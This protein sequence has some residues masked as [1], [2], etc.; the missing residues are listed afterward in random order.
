MEY[1]VAAT[2]HRSTRRRCRPDGLLSTPGTRTGTEVRS[3]SCSRGWGLITR[4]E[5]GASRAR[6][7]PMNALSRSMT[8]R[9]FWLNSTTTSRGASPGI[10]P[11]PET[12]RG[13]P[14]LERLRRTGISRSSSYPKCDPNTTRWS[15]RNGGAFS[16][17][18]RDGFRDDFVLQLDDGNP[19]LLGGEQHRREIVIHVARTPHGR[20]HASTGGAIASNINRR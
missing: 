16:C 12:S 18:Y 5:C 8:G 7:G 20:V 13:A 6:S 17:T 15:G 3:G 19:R 4:A 9:S 14:T 2:R 10:S 11:T 1:R